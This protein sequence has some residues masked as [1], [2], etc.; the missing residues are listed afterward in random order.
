MLSLVACGGGS[1]NKPADAKRAVDSGSGSA[2]TC[3]ATASYGAATIVAEG[4]AYAISAAE[5]ASDAAAGYVDA[6]QGYYGFINADAAPDKFEID[7]YENLGAFM[8]GS[9]SGAITTGT[10]TLGGTDL[11]YLNC[12]LC[13][14]IYTNIANDGTATD[15]YFATGGMVDL[16]SVGTPTGSGISTGTL[17]GSIS[18]VMFAHWDGSAD[19]AVGDCTSMITSLSFSG[20]IEPVADSFEGGPV[21]IVGRRTR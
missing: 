14:E 8:A 11:S 20:T 7:L 6:N 15:V 5:I 21:R 1:N 2:V 12:G 9:G 18:N 3:N 10:F 17:S 13:V 16:T 19:K 4:S